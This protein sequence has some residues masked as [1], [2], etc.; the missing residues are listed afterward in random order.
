MKLFLSAT[1]AL[2]LAPICAHAVPVTLRVADANG[3]PVADA[4]AR[5]IDYANWV[6]DA[7]TLPTPTEN[8]A[9]AEGIFALDLRGTEGD[10]KLLRASEGGVPGLGGARVKAPGFG[11]VNV[12]LFAGENRVTLGPASHV[13]GVVQ[14]EAGAP[15][16]SAKV[17]LDSVEEL[18][19][20]FGNYNA[21]SGLAPE[22]VATDAQGRWKMDGL[23]RGFGSFIAS[24]PDAV[25][26]ESIVDLDGPNV[27]APP[28]V[29]PPA[30]TIK[31]R[32]VDAQGR[33]VAGVNVYWDGGFGSKGDEFYSDANGNFA[34]DDVPLGENRVSFSRLNATWLGVDEEPEVELERQGQ[35]VD[36]GEIRQSVGLLLSGRVLDKNGGKPLEG[37]ELRAHY[38]VLQGG[39]DGRFVGRVSKPFYSLDAVN[40]YRLI[41]RINP[42][43]SFGEAVDVGDLTVE[44]AVKLPLDLRDEAGNAAPQAQLLFQS[45]DDPQIALQNNTIFGAE[46]ANIGPLP[47]G[48]YQVKSA[49]LWDVVAPKT[50]RI[51]ANAPAPTIAIT[52]RPVKPMT[53]SGRVVDGRGRGIAGAKIGVQVGRALQFIAADREGRWSGEFRPTDEKPELGEAENQNFTQLRGGAL[54]R[55]AKGNWQATDIIMARTDV[56]RAGRVV[57]ED[58]GGVAGARVSWEGSAKFEFATTDNTGQ[59]EIKGLPDAPLAVAASDGARLAQTTA[60]PGVPVEIELPPATKLAE[61][62]LEQLLAPANAEQLKSLVFYSDIIGESRVLDAVERFNAQGNPLEIG[63]LDRYLEML[64]Y[65][66]RTPDSSESVARQGVRLLR[67]F[68]VAE[69]SG[70]G[71]GRIALMAA[72]SPDADSRAWAEQWVDAQKS[73]LSLQRVTA[74]ELQNALR[75]AT[76]GAALNRADAS[77]ALTIALFINE[78]LPRKGRTDWLMLGIMLWNGD[79]QWL[80]EA[81]EDWEP[82]A[83]SMAIAGALG[84][85]RDVESGRVLLKRLQKLADAATPEESSHWLGNG[86][87]EFVRAAAPLDANAAYEVLQKQGAKR[88][89]RAVFAAAQSALASGQTQDALRIMQLEANNTEVRFARVCALALLAK[90]A[91]DSQLAQQ[92][93][94]SARGRI[95]RDGETLNA[96]DVAAY[97]FALH[98]FDAG[99]GRLLL[100]AQWARENSELRPGVDKYQRVKDLQDLAWAMAIYDVPRALQWLNSVPDQRTPLV[101]R[102]A[103]VRGGIFAI[104]FAT[105][106]QQALALERLDS[107]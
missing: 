24:A 51:D 31:G 8:R 103:S 65:R 47:S 48:N 20:G 80:Y 25:A 64:S 39:A 52:V 87:F 91:G 40:G 22:T 44:R 59:F 94:E 10:P 98:A 61:A 79:P 42:T 107:T 82:D 55:D 62:E 68:P 67:K 99:V 29:L 15:I 66:A 5:V 19:G 7:N 104:A 16:A 70:A 21:S 63:A 78:R 11:T 28:I 2:F 13:E 27:A 100:E 57:D 1:L 30:A 3:Q 84:Q 12:I 49:G 106:Q 26:T 58:G 102:A 101:G 90:S 83:Q 74:M 34:L 95:E 23:A 41:E 6:D 77:D 54:T 33:G 56:A 85:I 92:F 53:V 46:G 69:A 105:P 4:T 37:V 73:Q 81:I 36:I 89:T 14:D 71:A 43:D 88:P 32:I 93:I 97:A 75:V 86:E 96:H 35:I 17:R 9:G 18:S 76:V 72:R 38:S 50:V 60:T 45:L